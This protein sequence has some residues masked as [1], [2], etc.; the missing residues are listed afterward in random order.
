MLRKLRTKFI[1]LNMTTVAIVLTVVFVIICVINYQQ[2]INMVYST[3]DDALSSMKQTHVLPGDEKHPLNSEFQNDSQRGEQQEGTGLDNQESLSAEEYRDES[4]TPPEIGGR[5]EG[6]SPFIP[7]AVYS[8][9]NDDSVPVAESGYASASISDEVLTAAINQ[10]SSLDDDSGKLDDVG[11]FYRKLSQGDIVY[12]AFADSSA[13][14]GWQSLAVTLIGV[15][16]VTLLVFFVISVFFSR[17]A[18]KPVKQAWLQQQQFVADASHELKT[19]LTVVLANASILLT[20]SE[21]NIASQSQWIEST[22]TEAKRMQRLVNDLLYL[23][24]SDEKSA[25]DSQSKKAKRGTTTIHEESKATDFSYVVEGQI[26]QFESVAFERSV[27]LQSDIQENLWVNESQDKLERLS[28][29]LLDNAC[30]YAPENSTVGIVLKKIELKKGKTIA[31]FSVVNQGSVINQEDLSR[32][33][34]RF[35][36]ADKARTRTGGFGLGLAIAKEIAKAANGSISAVSTQE[37]GTV[38]TVDLPL[39][40]KP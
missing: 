2:S 8:V 21:Q 19:P 13:A 20:H 14:N 34:D 17:W 38:F 40:S 1:V 18:M 6:D 31:R 33:F 32:L 30:K 12:Y 28:S 22:Q 39:A 26:L 29:I 5:P 37:T 11:L 23:A 10:L 4:I 16:V 24:R 36:R 25:P 9:R 27:T 3:L 7:V 15:G 35:Y